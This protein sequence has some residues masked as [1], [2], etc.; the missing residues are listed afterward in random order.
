MLNSRFL[1]A[2]RETVPQVGQ[3]EIGSSTL[4]LD[5]GGSLRINSRVPIADASLAIIAVAGK[6][7]RG[8]SAQAIDFVLRQQLIPE[9]FEQNGLVSFALLPESGRNYSTGC[10]A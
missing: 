5:G 9:R 1:Y 7:V 10:N 4:S 3:K 6:R 2:H 8:I